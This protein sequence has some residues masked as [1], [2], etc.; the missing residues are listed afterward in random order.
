[1][2]VHASSAASRPLRAPATNE[3]NRLIAALGAARNAHQRW[4]GQAL[5]LLEGINSAGG[6]IILDPHA[7]EFSAWYYGPGSRLA[8]VPGYSAIES[9]HFRVHD[10]AK[11]IKP[12]LASEENSLLS[13]LFGMNSV[14]TSSKQLLAAQLT[15]HSRRIVNLLGQMEQ[16]IQGMSDAE[17]AKLLAPP[18]PGA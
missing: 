3:R 7:C 13:R 17:L 15:G 10:L 2:N 18:V 1:M 4:I 12:T 8:T 5:A 11:E 6:E 14:A 9:L 16:A